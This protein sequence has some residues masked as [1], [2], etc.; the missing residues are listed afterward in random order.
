MT[1]TCERCTQPA[2][3]RRFRCAICRRLVCDLCCER[4]ERTRGQ[5]SVWCRKRDLVGGR[6]PDDC[7]TRDRRTGRAA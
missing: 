4:I 1:R 3:R 5:R 2:K 6:M 7:K